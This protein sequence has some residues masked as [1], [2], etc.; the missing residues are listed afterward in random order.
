[1]DGFRCELYADP[2]CVDAQYFFPRPGRPHLRI[3]VGVA[4]STFRAVVECL[5]HEIG[6]A[7]AVNQRLTLKADMTLSN[8]NASDN[9]FFLMEHRQ[10]TE[11]IASSAYVVEAVYDKLKRVWQ[12]VQKQKGVRHG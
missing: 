9:R 10:Y 11:W 1:M 2:T 7:T 8:L 4:A 3:V 6:E 12:N 5:M